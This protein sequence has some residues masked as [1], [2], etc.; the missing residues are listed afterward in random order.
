MDAYNRYQK[1]Q[2]KQRTMAA[3]FVVLLQHLED[4]GAHLHR[5]L[6]Q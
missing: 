3:A 1:E 2:V 5:G 4:C 6:R